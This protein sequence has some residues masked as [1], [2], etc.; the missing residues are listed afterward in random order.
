MLVL[1]CSSST[2]SC[3]C[4]KGPRYLL[5][6]LQPGATEAVTGSMTSVSITLPIELHTVAFGASL[7]AGAQAGLLL[8]PT[9]CASA[10]AVCHS[11]RSLRLDSVSSATL[12]LP[13]KLV[14]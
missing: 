4:L 12:D 7:A 1:S 5:L 11:S 10:V 14:G 3:L 9:S 6:L 2:G 13:T 8:L